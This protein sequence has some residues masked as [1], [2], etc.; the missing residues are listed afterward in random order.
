MVPSV[1]GGFGEIYRGKL[2]DKTSVA[3][4]L[5]RIVAE[6]DDQSLNHLE[7]SIIWLWQLYLTS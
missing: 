2:S 6:S 1:T 5:T 4:K 7:V 3:I